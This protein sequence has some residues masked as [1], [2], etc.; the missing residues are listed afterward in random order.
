MDNYVT[1]ARLNQNGHTEF[2]KI[3]LMSQFGVFTSI[4]IAE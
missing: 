3:N 1:Q 2:K 4:L